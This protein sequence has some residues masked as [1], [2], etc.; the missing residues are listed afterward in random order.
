VTDL[1]STADDTAVDAE[2]APAVS[3]TC[4]QLEQEAAERPKS[5]KL[6]PRITADAVRLVWA[7]SPRILIAGIALKLVN[8][9]GLAT[10]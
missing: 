8:G 2:P 7:A 9:A 3:V 4:E 10:R 1:E 6:L 5:L